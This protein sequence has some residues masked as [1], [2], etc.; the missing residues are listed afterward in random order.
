[1]IY[2]KKRR[3]MAIPVLLLSTLFVLASC[4]REQAEI[5]TVQ[6]QNEP[7]QV[8][9]EVLNL[10]KLTPAQLDDHSL[11]VVATTSIIG[12]VVAN[13]GG[14]NIELLTLM[15]AGQDPHNFDPGTGEL[16]EVTEADVIFVN[17]WDLEE[18]LADDL[19]I[20]T[21]NIPIVAVGANI[22][23]LYFKNDVGK[24]DKG[25]YGERHE[26]GPVDPHTWLA[27]PNVVQWVENVEKIL[28]DL[29][30]DS[31]EVFKRN[32][33]AYVAELEEVDSYVR[34]QVERVP[35]NKRVLVTN[36]GAF[37]YLAQEYGFSIAGT[38]IPSSSTLAEPSASD[39]FELIKLMEAESVCTIFS[40]NTNND[41]LAQTV[42]AELHACEE[43]Q[44]LPLYSGSLGPP[45]SGGDSYIGMMMANVDTIVRGL[46]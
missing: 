36:H 6:I 42:A 35:V 46:E 24:F 29:D 17:G 22:E 19:A 14:E 8:K 1:M 12:D 31:A 38:V 3:G 5:E 30:V 33:Q 7:R 13:V 40:E 21:D 44:V 26:R 23:P 34:E 18:G 43:V 15:K 28:S 32:S 10:P 16:T 25:E 20:I 41:V 4:G 11:Q 37:S 2:G 45:G 9:S 27:V 39:L